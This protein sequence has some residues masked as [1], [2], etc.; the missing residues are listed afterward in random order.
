MRRSIPASPP[1]SSSRG[2]CSYC[3]SPRP[4]HRRPTR[5]DLHRGGRTRL[6]HRPRGRRGRHHRRRPRGRRRERG[7]GR[8]AV[9]AVQPSADREPTTPPARS[10]G[11]KAEDADGLASSGEELTGVPALTVSEP[12][13][14]QVLHGGGHL[15]PGRAHRRRRPVAGQ[16]R[17]GRV[18]RVDHAGGRRRRADGHGEDRGPRGPRRHR[19]LLDRRRLRR[20]GHRPGRP[21]ERRPED[22]EV[23]LVDPGT[24]AA[25]ALPASGRVGQGERRTAMPPIITRAQWG[26]DESIRRWDP[27]Y[28]PTIK[29]ATLHHTA[30]RNTYTAA[31]VPGMMRSIYAYHTVNRGWGDIGYNVIVD[32]FGRIFEG[33]YGDCQSPSSARTPAASTPARSASRCWATTPR[34][35]PA[36]DA[37]RG[38]RGHGLE[39]RRS[40]ASTPGAAHSSPPAAAARR[41]TQ[42]GPSSRCPRSSPTGTSATP[43]ARASTPTAGWG[44]SGPWC[45]PNG[46]IRRQPGGQSRDHVPERRGG[47]LRG[48]TFDPDYPA[49]GLTSTSS[50]TA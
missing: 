14:E 26:A 12:D 2:A 42:P 38:R 33:R 46:G 13:S 49:G 6:G 9:Q 19:A 24:S 31:D 20:R 37:R 44:R 32:K 15:A 10:G 36:G 43:R 4:P 23:A 35:H 39:A 48:W 45:W 28:A 27:E 29:A 25:D 30:D 50:S 3:R 40:T 8:S 16:G 17:R 5:R 18:G 1:S 11:A 21:G 22:V 7:G 47:A 41:S 34:R